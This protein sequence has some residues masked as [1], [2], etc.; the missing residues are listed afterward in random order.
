MT[1][2]GEAFIEVRSDLSPFIKNLD[3]EVKAAAERME[4]QFQESMSRGMANFS[5]KDSEKLGEDLGDGVGRGMRKKLGD[6][7]K[8]LYITIAAALGSAL[9]D[10]LSALPTEVKAGIVGGALLAMP[11]LSAAIAGATTAALGAG[12]AGLGTLLAFQYTEVEEAGF[13]LADKLR[14]ELVGAA[15][16]FVNVLRS[17]F[18]FLENRIEG[19][20]PRLDRIFS[21]ASTFVGPLIEGLADAF[22]F[23]TESFDNIGD[24]MKPF[25]KELANGF[26]ILGIAIGD[27]L[28]ILASTG[29]DGVEGLRDLF[30]AAAQLIG[31]FARLL[32]ILTWVYGRLRDIADVVPILVGPLSIIFEASDQA[33]TGVDQYG[34]ATEGL[35]EK[36]L[37]TISA[38]DRETK[39]LKE[40]AQAMDKARDSAFGLIDAT[41]NYEES[42]DDLSETLKENG[43]TFTIETEK[44]R[45]NI[46]AVGDAIK[47]AQADAEK[48]FQEGKLTA[49]QANALYQAEVTEILKIA[50]AHGITEQAVRGVYDEALKLVALPPP[51]VGWLNQ[52]AASANL[53][54][55]AL[56]RALNE[57]RKLNSGTGGGKGHGGFTEFA[58]GGIVD[59]PT[60]GIFGE[61]GAE[62]IIP[63][64]RPARAA[65]LMRMSGL[66]KMLA[67]ATPTVNVF[68]GNE[69]LDA[70][71]YRIVTDNNAALS[72]SLS[73]GARGL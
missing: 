35:T 27:S 22:D 19:L 6:K 70:R 47:A 64:T 61:A 24:G 25:V 45:E 28:E 53:T 10:G 15:E 56:Q 31:G 30:Y 8:P 32:Q 29:E 66:D 59:T 50:K 67:P 14:M 60:L 3:R 16:P 69:Q 44:G 11:F 73:F 38:T 13:K 43:R 65:E 58:D 72:S 37:G 71:T 34:N 39:S 18:Q 26:A 68:V 36:I 57:A 1:V 41:L 21:T 7:D 33:A 52:I 5:G 20:R 63:L 2:L 55:A 48:R 42:I 23:I 54:T 62:A 12:L 4:S 17:S 46:R 9:D 51:D 49:E 40:A